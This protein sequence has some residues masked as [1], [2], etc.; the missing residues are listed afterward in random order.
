MEDRKQKAEAARRD[1][2]N[3][4]ADLLAQ[5]EIQKD[6]RAEKN[7]L[8]SATKNQEAAY[9]KLL[10]EREQK[11]AQIYE[12]IRKIEDELKKQIDFGTLPSFGKGILLLPI[13]GGVLTQGFGNTSFAS[14]TDVYA[15]GFH[16]GVD[17]KAS[18]GTPVRA[19]DGGVVKATGNSDLLCPR[20]SYGKWVLIEHPNNLATLYAHFSLI[21]VSPRQTVGR[22]DIIGYSGNTGYVT[23]PH[24]HFTVYD[25]RTVQLRP[26]RICGVL[27]YGGYLNPL[28]Y[29]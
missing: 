1:L 15:N 23:G 29:L 21:R 26:S 25:A 6:A 4:Q 2:K 28:N 10:K 27:P 20:G 22:G 5:R 13:D 8:L 24:L 9:Q 12:E 16:N 14:Y 3:L 7:S 11:R 17:F 19:A 18:I